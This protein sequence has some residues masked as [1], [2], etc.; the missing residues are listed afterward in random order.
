MHQRKLRFQPKR[1]N[2]VVFH[3][4]LQA[5]VWCVDPATDADADLGSVGSVQ[6]ALPLDGLQH[7]VFIQSQ[8]AQK[9]EGAFPER[10]FLRER[11]RHP[12][13]AGDRLWQRGKLSVLPG[14]LHG[15][16]HRPQPALPEVP[17][18]EHGRERA[19]DL[20]GGRGR[21]RWEHG[22]IRGRVRGRRG[23]HLGAVFGAERRAGSAGGPTRPETR[24]SDCGAFRGDGK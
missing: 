13:S 20:R 14:R 3:G 1:E 8:N 11:R 5:L 16:L 23:R 4:N 10:G 18:Q 19:P 6:A 2:E 12:S 17:A 7:H 21:L 9:E 24:E 22:R 15:D